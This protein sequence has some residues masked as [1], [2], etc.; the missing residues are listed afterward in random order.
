MRVRVDPELPSMTDCGRD[1]VYLNKAFYELVMKDISNF[2][3]RNGLF[4]QIFHILSLIK[5]ENLPY[6]LLTKYMLLK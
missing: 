5:L 6:A 3:N 2:I 4:E 1:V